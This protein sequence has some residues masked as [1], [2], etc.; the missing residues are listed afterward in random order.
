[1]GKPFEKQTRFFVLP[2]CTV[3]SDQK[4]PIR[5]GGIQ[6]LTAIATACE[7]LDALIHGLTAALEVNQPLQRAQLLGWIVD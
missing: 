3:L 1:M 5:A 7:G 4:A 2:V 6:T